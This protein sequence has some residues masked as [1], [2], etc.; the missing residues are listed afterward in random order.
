LSVDILPLIE[1]MTSY[2]PIFLKSKAGSFTEPVF[3]VVIVASVKVEPDGVRTLVTIFDPAL[4]PGRV[5]AT[6]LSTRTVRLAFFA[7]TVTVVRFDFDVDTS[8]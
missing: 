2:T 4:T 5:I 3:L 7:G 1:V 6:F 8:R